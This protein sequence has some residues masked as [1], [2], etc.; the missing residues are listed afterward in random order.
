MLDIKLIRENP[1]SISVMLKHRQI[2]YPLEELLKLDNDRRS[3][4]TKAQELKELR[5][6]TSQEVS[7]VKRNGGEATEKI[8]RMKAISLEIE[9]ADRQISRIEADTNS[10]IERLPNIPHQSVPVGIGESSNLLLHHWG[11]K[12]HF[13]FDVKDHIEIGLKHG[14]IDVERAAKLAGSRFYHLNRELV[15]LNHAI[16]ALGLDLLTERHFTLVQPPYL[17]NRKSM[18]GAVMLSDFEDVIYKVEGEDLY[19]IGTS[20]H[21]LVAMHQGE[22]LDAKQLPLRYAGISPC[23]RKEAGSHGRDT[24]GI[25][26]VHQFEKVEQVIMCQ[27]TDSETLH[28]EMLGNAEAFLRLLKIPYRVV[29]LSTGEMGK[30]A[31]KT[32]DIEAWFPGQDKYREIVSCS[33]CTDYQARSLG[34]RFRDKPHQHAQLVHFLNSTLVATERTIIA[35]MEN[36]QRKDGSIGV[37]EALRPY[38]KGMETIPL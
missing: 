19:L 11:E 27:P 1:E 18:G 12:P 6:K 10:L 25:F 31:A 8:Q 13:D 14:L 7:D 28:E 33:N 34:I 9:K 22:I 36:Y 2:D 15:L 3:L 24:K 37:P 21:P 29:L 26:R 4:V 17:L 38:L 20:E 5:N 23:F 30:I 35:I 16:I 32:Y